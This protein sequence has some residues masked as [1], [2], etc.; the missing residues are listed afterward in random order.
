M[1]R[2]LKEEYKQW[3]LEINVEKTKYLPIGVV[4][5]NIELENNKEITSCSEYT[6]L[7]VIFYR[8]GKDDEEI[9]K[10]VTQARRTIG[11]LNEIRW[12][13]EIGIKRKYN[14]YKT[15]IKSSLVYGAETWRIT[16]NNRKKLEAVEMDMFKRTL[17]ISRKEFELRK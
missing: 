3:G 5:S 8:T 16:E 10:R 6:Y 11:C 2:K 14:I 13:S 12:S 1:A 7:R 15:L 9:K 4:L 17:G